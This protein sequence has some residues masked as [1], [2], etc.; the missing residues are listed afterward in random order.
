MAI[1]F[2]SLPPK[3]REVKQKYR[4]GEEIQAPIIRILKSRIFFKKKKLHLLLPPKASIF[5][6]KF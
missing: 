3:R 4:M 2:S 5:T 6:H 1:D